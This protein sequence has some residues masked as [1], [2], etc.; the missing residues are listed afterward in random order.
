MEGISSQNGIYEMT[1]GICRIGKAALRL[2]DRTRYWQ[3]AHLRGKLFSDN[4]P[5]L[6]SKVTYT[7]WPLFSINDMWLVKL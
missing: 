2:A 7:S 3:G 5:F 6:V 4:P 1:A